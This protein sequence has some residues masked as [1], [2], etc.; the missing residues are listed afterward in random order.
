[1]RG[2]I[3]EGRSENDL[4]LAGLFC[5]CVPKKIT[6]ANVPEKPRNS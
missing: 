3:G 6:T 4:A 1:V 2:E 5:L